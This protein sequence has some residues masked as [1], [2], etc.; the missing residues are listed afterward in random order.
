[1]RKALLN[2]TV[3]VSALALCGC[4]IPASR[5]E[6]VLREPAPLPLPLD[7]DGEVVP[8]VV[9]GEEI[10]ISCDVLE[11][12]KHETDSDVRVVLTLAAA[13]G[14]AGPGYKKVLA[15]DEERI[16]GS[17]RV[18]IPSTPDIQE[19]TVDLTVYVLGNQGAQFC[20]GGHLKISASLPETRR[21][22]S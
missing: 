4:A 1:M 10:A 19:H 5:N 16:D 15:T 2:A 3:L 14:D 17:V 11:A 22:P 13:P 12:T 8:I 6:I 7:A 21:L 20:D 9:P 18:K